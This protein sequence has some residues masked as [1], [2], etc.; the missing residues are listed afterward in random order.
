MTAT[1]SSQIIHKPKETIRKE[2]GI[3]S[4]VKKY[5]KLS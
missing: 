2:Q 4:E 1:Q 5:S 3:K